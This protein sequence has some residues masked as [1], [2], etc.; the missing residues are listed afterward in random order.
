MRHKAQRV[1]DH[2]AREK[3][4]VERADQAEQ[5]ARE[6]EIVAGHLEAKLI[7]VQERVRALEGALRCVQRDVGDQHGICGCIGTALAPPPA[8]EG[9]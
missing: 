6:W 2:I 4:L 8:E 3:V 5:R 1:L 7:D 9:T